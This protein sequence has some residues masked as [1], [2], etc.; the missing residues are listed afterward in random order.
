MFERLDALLKSR[1]MP[2]APQGMADRI[3]ARASERRKSRSSG[4]LQ[5]L[6]AEV[7]ALIDVPGEP[8]YALAVLFVLGLVLGLLM[9]GSI[10][11][12]GMDTRDLAGLLEVNDRFVASEWV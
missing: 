9:D 12:A 2:P 7:K 4:F 6:W 3:I 10:L 8:A 11:S 5:E 1:F